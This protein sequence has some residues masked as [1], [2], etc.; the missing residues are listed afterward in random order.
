MKQNKI[1]QPEKQSDVNLENHNKDKTNETDS[2][3]VI[4]KEEALKPKEELFKNT[5]SKPADEQQ[6]EGDNERIPKS[7]N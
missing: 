4:T 2:S 6:F 3:D 7:D 5:H 1:I